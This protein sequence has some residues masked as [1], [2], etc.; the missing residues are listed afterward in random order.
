MYVLVK[1]C[2]SMSFK[3]EWKVWIQI[4]MRKGLAYTLKSTLEKKKIFV[5]IFLMR[6]IIFLIAIS[7]YLI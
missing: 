1:R 6:F 5:F 4:Q 3:V 2:T 7:A